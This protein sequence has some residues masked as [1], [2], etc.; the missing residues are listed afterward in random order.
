MN[1]GRRTRRTRRSAAARSAT[2][3]RSP[4]EGLLQVGDEVA[5]VLDPH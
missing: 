3:A 2:L 1:R 5:R 4:G